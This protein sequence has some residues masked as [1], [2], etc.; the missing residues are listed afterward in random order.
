MPFPAAFPIYLAAMVALVLIVSIRI[1]PHAG[2][3]W[4]V[5][6]HSVII[7]IMEP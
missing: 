4:P 7:A 2:P 1:A 6:A 5:R 3:R